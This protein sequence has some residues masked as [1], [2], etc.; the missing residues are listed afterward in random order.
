VHVI[1]HDADYKAQKLL[2]TF[3]GEKIEALRRSNDSERGYW[4]G[5]A[6]ARKR[7]AVSEIPMRETPD[8]RDRL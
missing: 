1:A 7:L 3:L 5:I 6:P 2:D 4:C 8:L